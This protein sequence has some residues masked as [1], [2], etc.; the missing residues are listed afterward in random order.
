MRC[1][2]TENSVYGASSSR[3]CNGALPIVQIRFLILAFSD[4]YLGHFACQEL[5]ASV[6]DAL[7]DWCFARQPQMCIQVVSPVKGKNFSLILSIPFFS[8][9][10]RVYETYCN[11]EGC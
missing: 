6:N 4:V 7:F 2:W 1:N 3:F 9:W 5:L 11:L 8:Q 10:L